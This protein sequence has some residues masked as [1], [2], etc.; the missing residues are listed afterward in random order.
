MDSDTFSAQQN[1]A[2]CVSVC[3]CGGVDNEISFVNDE[4]KVSGNA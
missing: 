4:F 2:M 1:E 3:A